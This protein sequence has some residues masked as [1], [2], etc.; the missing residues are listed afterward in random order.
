MYN[1][2]DFYYINPDELEPKYLPYYKELFKVELP[3]NYS[4]VNTYKL[5]N[6]Y[7]MDG[8]ANHIYEYINM[9]FMFK[10][11]YDVIEHRYL[12]RDRAGNITETPVQMCDRVATFVAMAE[13]QDRIHGMEYMSKWYPIFLKKLINMEISPNTPTWVSAGIP[14]FGSFACVVT[15]NDDSLR[16][17]SKWYKDTMYL[18]RYNFGIGHSLHKFRPANTP[19]SRSKV[20]TKSSLNWLYPIQELA[21]NMS[22]GASGRGGANMVTIPVWHPDVLEFIEHKKFVH[23]PN[24]GKVNARGAMKQIMNS[25]LS[26]NI[27][28]DLVDVIDKNI[29][30]KNFNMS[31]LINDKFMNAVL[32]EEKW[33]ASFELPDHAYIYKKEYEACEIYRLI[34]QNAWESGDPGLLFYD[35]INNDNVI[36]KVKN[37]IYCTNPCGEIPLH[38]NSVCNLWT[39]NL[40]KHIDFYHRKISMGK[41]KDTINIGVRMADNLTTVNSYPKE[42]SEIEKSAKEERRTGIDFTGLADYLYVVGMKFACQ[43]SIREID[44]L[45]KFLRTTAREYS[46]RLGKKKGSF[47]LYK[48]SDYRPSKDLLEYKECSRCGSKLERFDD[49][50]Q[51][52]ECNWAKFTYI[53]NMHL[54]TQAPTGTRSRKLGVS[55]GIEPQFYKW[56]TSNVMEGKVVYDVNRILEWYIK[57]ECDKTSKDFTD[58]CAQI[59]N[60]ELSMPLLDNWV[61]AHELT[62]DQH[63]LVQ[64]TAQKWI[65]QAVSKTINLPK[66]AVADDVAK[67]YMK[68]WKLGCKGITIYRDGSHY[69]EVIGKSETCSE[70]GSKD[71]LKIEGCVQCMK[72]AWSKC[73][74]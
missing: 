48:K 31:V 3:K 29:P 71:L 45:Y 14:D 56:Y 40:V 69:K 5:V 65:D 44:G 59:D 63:L 27:K 7:I 12:M 13:P 6:Q 49:F 72:C 43:E 9:F 38:P 51:C 67:I 8:T 30:L 10:E 2:E 25:D 46:A 36:K 37:S 58:V 62:A 24:N 50:I 54:L 20:K 42:V 1:E 21:E 73:S 60:K 19:F 28:K 52:S 15:D 18:N 70:C 57:V 32:N 74:M 61:E 34:C 17:I 22:Q 23:T 68:A 33:E 4:T 47:P 66:E 64:A 35:R 55:F 39:V 11:Q 16:G 53:R 41:L 26:P